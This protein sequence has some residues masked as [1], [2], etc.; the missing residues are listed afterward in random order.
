MNRFSTFGSRP[1]YAAGLVALGVLLLLPVQARAQGVTTG[2][3]L[4]IVTN[5]Q[6]QTVE[7]A[8]VIAIHEPSGTTYE[9]VT[10]ADGRFSILGMRVGGPY[11][12]V[13]NYVGAGG[14]FEPQR[15]TDVTVN[16]GVSTDVKVEV[17]AIAVTETVT[18]TGTSADAVF[19]SNRT[20]AAT[21]VNRDTLGAPPTL[22]GR[23]QDVTR[24]TPQASG[25]NFVG[26]DSRMNNITVD[27]SS[28]NN[29]FGL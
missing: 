6:G 2:A 11:S 9:S 23:I 22:S 21:A 26:Q 3:M 8:S 28:F 15:I 20:G 25:T 16:L 10:R 24:L 7:G 27:G 19:S 29:S 5:T 1:G 18:V 13:V 4:G 14:A 12:V 17:K